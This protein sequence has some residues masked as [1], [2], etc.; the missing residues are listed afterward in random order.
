M[1]ERNGHEDAAPRAAPLREQLRRLAEILVIEQQER[2][3]AAVRLLAHSL[4]RTAADLEPEQHRLVGRYAEDAA[5]QFERF[6]ETVRQQR[7][8]GLMA[9]AERLARRQPALFL[10]GAA[11]AGF[12]LGR[13]LAAPARGNARGYAMTGGELDPHAGY[14]P[15]AAPA[16]DAA[17]VMERA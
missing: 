10:A 13:V 2:V 1:A 7:L 8:S 12:V 5:A 14:P 6:S 15:A 17:A 3:A 16:R 11:A 9:Q 4:R